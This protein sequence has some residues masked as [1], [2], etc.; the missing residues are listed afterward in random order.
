MAPTTCAL[1]ISTPTTDANDVRDE[2]EDADG[3]LLVLLAG[4]AITRPA[5]DVSDASPAASSA[6]NMSCE[7]SLRHVAPMCINER[8]Y[9]CDTEDADGLVVA[10]FFFMGVAFSPL[11]MRASAFVFGVFLSSFCVHLSSSS[12][13]SSSCSLLSLSFFS[14]SCII[15]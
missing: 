4:M 6:L 13:S 5:C 14:L 2:D 1:S 7:D 9:H 12:S 15:V 10:S 8:G 11:L 3:V